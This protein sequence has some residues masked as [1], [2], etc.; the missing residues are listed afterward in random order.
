MA[1]GPVVPARAGHYPGAV[2]LVK[3]M[4]SGKALL[5][6]VPLVVAGGIL[7][8]SAHTRVGT[9]RAELALT[10]AQGRAEGESYL[11]TLQGSHAQRQLDLL[12]HH[13]EVALQL[14]A[15][16]RDRLLGLLVVLA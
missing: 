13:H 14:A 10:D 6:S 16:R 7:M 9:L 11:Q 1:R 4:I 8:G 2:S 3:R 15:A 12:T 5:V